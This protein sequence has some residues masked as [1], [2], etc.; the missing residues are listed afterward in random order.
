[1]VAGVR[2]KANTPHALPAASASRIIAV[3]A[4]PYNQEPVAMSAAYTP[5]HPNTMERMPLGTGQGA[6][7]SAVVGTLLLRIRPIQETDA[8]VEDAIETSI[9][10]VDV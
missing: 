9:P 8:G 3:D 2:F 1:M 7:A 6:V 4:S 10:G 5:V